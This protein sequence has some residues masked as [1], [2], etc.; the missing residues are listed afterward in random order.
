M[1]GN[2]DSETLLKK[3]LRSGK[4]AEIL[5]EK[6]QKKDNKSA[7]SKGGDK[8][9]RGNKNNNNEPTAEDQQKDDVAGDK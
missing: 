4:Y 7:K 1:T 6:P 8:E 3:L 5:P 9:N 2:V